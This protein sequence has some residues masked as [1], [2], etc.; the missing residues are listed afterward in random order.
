MVTIPGV[1]VLVVKN[2]FIS[3]RLIS[4]SGSVSWNIMSKVLLPFGTSLSP[5]N[6]LRQLGK[7]FVSGSMT[8]SITIN[9]SCCCVRYSVF[10]N[11]VQCL[12][13]TTFSQ[14]VDHLTTYSPNSDPLFYT[15]RFMDGLR[16]DIRAIVLVQHP[17]NFDTACHL[18]LLQEEVGAAPPSRPARTGDWTMPSKLFPAAKAPVALPA[19]PKVDKAAPLVGLTPATTPQPDPALKALKADH[20]RCPPEVLM[21]VEMI[22]QDFLEDEAEPVEDSPECSAE[23]VCLSGCYPSSGHSVPRNG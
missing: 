5:L 3:T 6:C 15:Q 13:V 18:A 1:G 21:A 2:I 12:N 10:A 17:P 16:H 20:H 8:D 4:L 14:L 22:W 9:M 11:W 19:P 7:P 23:Q